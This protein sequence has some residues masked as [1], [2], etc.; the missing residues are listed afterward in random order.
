M[1]SN[2]FYRHV[3]NLLREFSA[4]QTIPRSYVYECL[5]K[6]FE[7]TPMTRGPVSRNLRTQKQKSK[8]SRG[9]RL[10]QKIVLR[11]KKLEKWG[12]IQLIGTTHLVIIDMDLTP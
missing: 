3:D 6:D 10:N 7:D 8:S 1:T 9:S 5:S 11:L 12:C 4:G 2:G